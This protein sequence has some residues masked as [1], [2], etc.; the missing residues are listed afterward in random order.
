MGLKG[1]KTTS[2]YIEWEKLQNLILKL[3]RDGNYKFSLLMSIGSYT[4]LRI[5]DILNLKWGDI[6][7]ADLLEVKEK[8]TG[9]FRRIKINQNLKETI[10]RISEN[11]KVYQDDYV[12][13]NKFGTSTISVQYVNKKLKEIAKKYNIC[14]NPE[15]IKSHSIRKSFGRRVFENND[16]SERALILLNEIFNH[17]NIK[18]TKIYL[19]IREQEIFDVYENL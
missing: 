14:K 6:L 13:L 16:N 5:S 2:D 4:G 9:K 18:T 11:E 19:G 12:F 8:K 15:K 10:Q 1:Q 7:E 17:S 3:E